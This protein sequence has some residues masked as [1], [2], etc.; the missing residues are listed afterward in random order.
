M[1]AD[2]SLSRLK[3]R[4]AVKVLNNCVALLN[5]DGYAQILS[6]PLIKLDNPQVID[7]Q[8]INQNQETLTTAACAS[9]ADNRKIKV[10]DMYRQK[11]KSFAGIVS[12]VINLINN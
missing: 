12:L 7:S 10:T 1:L 6:K 11:E 3:A 5:W 9:C 8:L 4:L 2:G